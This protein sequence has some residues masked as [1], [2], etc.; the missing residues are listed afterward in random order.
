MPPS[1]EHR[2]GSGLRAGGAKQMSVVPDD[3][4]GIHLYLKLELCRE[5]NRPE[6]PNRIVEQIPGAC[7][8]NHALAEIRHPAVRIYD[9]ILDV[10][11]GK[12]FLVKDLLAE[13][14]DAHQAGGDD[15]LDHEMHEQP[16]ERR[17]VEASQLHAPQGMA[18]AR[19]AMGS[20][21]LLGGLVAAPWWRPLGSKMSF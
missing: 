16:A 17:L 1:E 14:I 2:P 18:A 12:G 13:G 20:G 5:T 19:Q 7:F 6:H 15:G 11:C 3:G 4:G 21:A 8:S 9:R 10:G